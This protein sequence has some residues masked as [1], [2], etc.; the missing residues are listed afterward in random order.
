MSFKNECNVGIKLK[1]KYTHEIFTK[2]RCDVISSSRK[3]LRFSSE[4]IETKTLL[5]CNG[6][7]FD[8]CTFIDP[9]FSIILRIC[10]LIFLSALPPP[11]CSSS[12]LFVSSP[13]V[14]LVLWSEANNH[15]SRNKLLQL[16]LCL[17]FPHDSLLKKSKSNIYMYSIIFWQKNMK[18]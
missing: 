17:R 13:S 5:S 10:R 3:I 6:F 2:G 11:L 8:F 12:P 15:L 9:L 1:Y 7:K 14:L 18:Y 16:K 4:A